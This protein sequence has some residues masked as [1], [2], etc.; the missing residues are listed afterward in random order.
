MA[1]L[2]SSDMASVA[3]VPRYKIAPPFPITTNVGSV[4]TPSDFATVS[5]NDNGNHDRTAPF[6]ESLRA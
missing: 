5:L 6:N 3:E 1:T 4:F 2:R